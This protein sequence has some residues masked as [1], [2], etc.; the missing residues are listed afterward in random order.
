MLWL[1]YFTRF[2]RWRCLAAASL[3][4]VGE[5]GTEG[6]L[7]LPHLHGSLESEMFRLKLRVINEAGAPDENGHGHVGSRLK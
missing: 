6:R 2:P 7:P 4:P 3:R 5:E 1:R